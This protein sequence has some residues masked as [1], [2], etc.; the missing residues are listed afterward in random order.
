MRVRE[1][2][3]AYDAGVVLQMIIWPFSEADLA[4]AA[5]VEREHL[6][7]AIA[8]LRP[9]PLRARARGHLPRGG[10]GAA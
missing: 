9:L 10:D 1:N 8:G 6:Y 2:L 7:Q 4:Q 5:N 3:A